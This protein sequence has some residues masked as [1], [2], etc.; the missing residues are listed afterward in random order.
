MHQ[1]PWI[2]M[3]GPKWGD[4][5]MIFMSDEVRRENHWQSDKKSLFTVTN[6]SFH[7]W[8]AILC[9]EHTIP[10]K[11]KSTLWRQNR[12]SVTSRANLGYFVIFVGCSC[13]RKLAHRR[14]SLVNNSI[15]YRFL[16]TRYSRLCVKEN[17]ILDMINKFNCI[18]HI[19]DI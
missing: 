4:L 16:I 1:S 7:F 5:S 6:V 14:S 9:P 10:L 18:R 19:H 3:F 17:A 2:T 15:E 11:Q 8:H 12:W 13:T